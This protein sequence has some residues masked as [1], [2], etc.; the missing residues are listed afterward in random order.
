MSRVSNV[1]L[2]PDQVTK[3]T[4]QGNPTSQ[5]LYMALYV[6]SLH[7]DLLPDRAPG[8]TCPQSQCDPTSETLHLESHIHGPQGLPL[9]DPVPGV[10]CP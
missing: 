9:S 5:N 6:H 4:V 2:P 10:T 3:I 1:T 8:I 7:D